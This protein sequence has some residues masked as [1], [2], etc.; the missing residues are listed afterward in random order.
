MEKALQLKGVKKIDL[1]YEDKL[2]T[3]TVDSK[4][5]IG[6]AE[7]TKAVTG[8]FKV[9]KVVVEGLLGSVSKEG[10]TFQARDSK[11]KYGL[12]EARGKKVLEK[13]LTKL[14]DKKLFRLA[15]EAKEVEI[16]DPETGKKKKVLRLIL[17]K[18]EE[19]KPRDD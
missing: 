3:L 18:F 8:R 9:S 2:F 10:P 17:A 4:S 13:L 15:G 1:K 12:V 16:R 5:A 6:P 19:V 14:G 11:L 7:L